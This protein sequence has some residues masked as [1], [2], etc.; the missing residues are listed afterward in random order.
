MPLSSG[1]NNLKMNCCFYYNCD[2]STDA[3]DEFGR[4]LK[5]WKGKQQEM[6]S[7]FKRLYKPEISQTKQRKRKN[8]KRVVHS[9]KELSSYAGSSTKEF[10]VKVRL[11]EQICFS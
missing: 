5:Y 4:L 3:S 1:M 6:E 7:N 11:N 10:F 2:I 9:N 8:C